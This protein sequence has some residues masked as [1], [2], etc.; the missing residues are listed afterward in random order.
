MIDKR[1]FAS[2]NPEERKLEK[3]IL[4][5]KDLGLEN[6]L[7]YDLHWVFYINDPSCKAFAWDA[8]NRRIFFIHDDV[9]WF[10]DGV[11]PARGFDKTETV[12]HLIYYG[13]FWKGYYY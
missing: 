1:V 9:A 12:L 13:F 2:Y 10:T 7:S 11:N 3:T 8:E 4:E 6:Q 5:I